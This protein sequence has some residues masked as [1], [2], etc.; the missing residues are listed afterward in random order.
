MHVLATRRYRP[1]TVS[2][3]HI[4]MPEDQIT[5]RNWWRWGGD[6]HIEGH[7]EAAKLVARKRLRDGDFHVF[8]QKRPGHFLL[9]A[10]TTG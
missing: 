8:A 4:R 1:D 10:V 7:S 2:I 3:A 6:L 5:L 9:T